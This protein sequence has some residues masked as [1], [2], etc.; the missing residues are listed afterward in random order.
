[1]EEKI[2]KKETQIRKSTLNWGKNKK[3]TTAA[4]VQQRT[5]L[6]T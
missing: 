2:I 1:M 3:R 4:S 6:S 5:L